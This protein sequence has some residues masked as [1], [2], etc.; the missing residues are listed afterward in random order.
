M[1][2]KNAFVTLV[3]LCLVGYGALKLYV[4]YRAKDNFQQ[5]LYCMGMP[6]GMSVSAPEK[7]EYFDYDHISASVFGPV[8]IK[9]LKIRIPM[10]DEEITFGEVLLTYDYDGDIKTCPTPKHINF[11][12]NNLKMNVS[13]LEKIA[14][15][16]EKFKE[17]QGIEDDEVPELV[18]RLGYAD[19]YTRASDFRA[20]G[21]NE[22]NIDL[23]F[24][25]TFN[26]EDME[27]TFNVH[28]KMKGMGDFSFTFTVAGMAKNINSAV[29][30]AKLKE[31]KLEYTDES[32]VNR[33]FKMFAESNKEDVNAYRNTVVA[34]LPTDFNSKQIKLGA[35]SIKNLTD[36]LQDPKRLIVTMYPYEPVGIESIKLYKPGDVPMLLNVQIYT[37]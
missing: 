28:E 34:G 30:G 17:R 15:Q 24:D 9:G 13:L 22:L 29:L 33:L 21:Y 19:L 37:K 1:R 3:V 23:G 31:A 5:I 6:R 36:F 26:K 4:Y 16:K 25:L 32:Y 2:I 12:V 11:T 10:F 14:K 20:L 8:G 7:N 35:D 18:R 27:A